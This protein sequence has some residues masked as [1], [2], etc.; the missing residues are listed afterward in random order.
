ML[1]VP[2]FE[3]CGLVTDDALLAARVSSLFRKSG[4]YFVV[5]D[6]PRMGRPDSGNEIVRR[7]NALTLANI[8]DL[9]LSDPHEAA[10]EPLRDGRARWLISNY[11]EDV[12][13]FL[14]GKVKRPKSALAWGHSELGIGLYLAKL[15]GRELVFDESLS[16]KTTLI[17]RGRHLLVACERGNE[18]AQVVACNVAY[19]CDASFA[20]FPNLPEKVRKN[21]IERLYALG[22]GE[23]VAERFAELREMVSSHIAEIDFSPY[24]NVLFITDGFPWGISISNAPT[25]HMLL[26]PDL[27][28]STVYGIW[29][30]QPE[31]RGSRTALLIDPQKVQGAEIPAIAEALVN[32]GTLVRRLSGPNSSASLVQMALDVLPN[33]IVVLSSH[34]GDVPGDRVTYSFPDAN[35]RGRQLVVDHVTYFSKDTDPEM[36]LVSE[37]HHFHSLDGVAWDNVDEESYSGAPIE[38][39]KNLGESLERRKYAVHSERITRVVGS[40]AIALHDGPWLF[41]SHGFH[42]KTAPVVFNNSCWSWHQLG[43]KFL[44]AGARAYVGCLYPVLDVEAQE[45]AVRVFSRHKDKELYRAVWHA[46]NDAYGSSSRR[47]YV[48]F[49]LPF[50]SIKENRADP[51]A[52]L[53]REYH[54]G[55]DDWSRIARES[56]EPDVRRNAAKNAQFMREDFERFIRRYP[57]SRKYPR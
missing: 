14:K 52:F 1:P 51:I 17:E 55:M 34:S 29:A 19:S 15:S 18:L 2:K 42:Q 11:F 40:M 50:V 7:R 5:M 12:L 49:G 4:R 46:Q 33:D 26:Y 20:T 43:R 41:A 36:V 57:T 30:S 56:S 48:V 54:A 24:K 23:N 10:I 3:T 39:W 47:P 38:S 35:G 31:H 27:G 16:T 13:D 53:L 9:I 45:V 44:F 32:N 6:R 22:D 8:Q 28:R 21:W 37:L 25:T